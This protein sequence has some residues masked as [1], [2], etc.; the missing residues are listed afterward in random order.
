MLDASDVGVKGAKRPWNRRNF[1]RSQFSLKGCKLVVANSG[2]DA[3][4]SPF[5]E[6]FM[7]KENGICIAFSVPSHFCI[8]MQETSETLNRKRQ[9][10]PASVEHFKTSTEMAS[11]I[12]ECS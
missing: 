7:S 1:L 2:D 4:C 12:M 10:L 5:H 9:V 6:L 8:D 11:S 3:T